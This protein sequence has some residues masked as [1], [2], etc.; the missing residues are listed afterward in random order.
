MKICYIEGC[1]NKILISQAEEVIVLEKS[2]D[3]E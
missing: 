3:D 2:L 1:G